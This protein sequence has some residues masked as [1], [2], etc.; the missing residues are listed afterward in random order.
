MKKTYQPSFLDENNKPISVISAWVGLEKI[1]RPIV[2]DFNLN[3]KRA[4]EIGVDYG[5]S[6]SALSNVFEEVI[7]VDMFCGDIHAGAR[8]ESQ[9][10]MV[11]KNFSEVDNVQ[12]IKSSY[13]EYFDSLDKQALFDLVHVDIVHTFQETYDCGKLALEHSRCVIF[14]DTESFSDVNRACEQLSVDFG[15]EIFN[16]PYSHGLG[17]LVKR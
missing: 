5:Y 7:G 8:D 9:Y 15:C 14:H 4:L 10:Q 13:Q 17:I 2:K 11:L 3:T 16:Y 1:I 12:I 6:L